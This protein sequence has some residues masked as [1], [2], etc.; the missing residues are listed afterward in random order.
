[1]NELQTMPTQEV[2]H[3]KN[4]RRHLGDLHLRGAQFAFRNGTGCVD[5]QRRQEIGNSGATNYVLEI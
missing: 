5:E 1:M 2:D 4:I 3:E